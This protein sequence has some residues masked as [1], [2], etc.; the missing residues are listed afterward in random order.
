MV[1][2]NSS[3]LYNRSFTHDSLGRLTSLT[4]IIEGDTTLFGYAYNEIGYLVEVKENSAVTAEY[5]YDANGNRTAYITPSD[6]ITASYDNQDRML[7]Y[8]QA[9]YVYGKR[10]DLQQKIVGADTTTYD[11]DNLGNL[12]SVVLPD[13]TLIEYLIDGNGRRVA[14]KVNGQLTKH[15]LYAGGLLP[16][17]ELDSTGA[18]QKRYGPGYIVK[19]DTTYRVIKDHLGSVRMVV[20][21]QTGEVVQRIDYDAWGNITYLQNSDEF[22]DIGFAGGLYDYDTELIRFGAR[23]YDPEVGRWT[24]KDPILFAGGT[25]NLYQYISNDPVNNIDPDG[26]LEINAWTVYNWIG[27]DNLNALRDFAAGISTGA[28]GGLANYLFDA[29][30]DAG[31]RDKCSGFYNAGWWTGAALDAVYGG[32][33]LFKHFAKN[34]AKSSTATAR[35]LGIAGERAVGITGPKTAI[36]VAGRTRIPDALTRTTL[37]EVKNV[38]SL[39]FT[40]QLRDYHTFSQQTGRDFILYT[41]PDRKSVV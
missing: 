2:Y 37:T 41:R 34:A 4:E 36:N 8:G 3:A 24:A 21:S 29:L 13:G 7:T 1:E 32:R 30:G 9:S 28:T 5:Q 23:D 39:S 35:R 26:L 10:G 33:G 11:Y 22:T 17:A 20:N 19:N 40:R 27:R 14:K 31:R 16:V 18:V 12:R 6:T 25:S 38:K 15:W